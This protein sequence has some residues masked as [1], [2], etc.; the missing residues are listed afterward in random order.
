[1]TDTVWTVRTLKTALDD[2][3]PVRTGEFSLRIV[4]GADP[5]LLVTMHQHGDLEA[6]VNVSEEQIAASVLLW[7]CDEQPD[8]AAFNEFLLKAQKLVPLSNFG[9]ATVDDRDFYELFGELATNSPLH[10]IETELRALAENAIEAATD[11][12]SAFSPA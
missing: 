2:S 4:E 1:M 7:P 12:R 10:T 3:D 9:I 5:V 6:Y 8:R 11:L